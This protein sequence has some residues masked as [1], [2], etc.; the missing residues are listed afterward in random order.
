M[1]KKVSFFI[2]AI[3]LIILLEGCATV[4]QETVEL[5]YV[6]EENIVALKVSYIKLV[7]THF[8][9]LEQIRIDYL[10]KDWLPGYIK[11]WVD[12]GRLIDIATG[13]VVWSSEY[14]DYVQPKKDQEM[15]GLLATTTVWSIVAIKQ[16]E[17]KKKELISPLEDQ[18]KELLFMIEEGFDRLL[19]GNIAITAHLNSIR[20]IKESQNKTF[21][22]LK[23]GDLQREIDRRLHDISMY[24]DQGLEA[25]KKN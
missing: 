4:P 24:A 11:I 22:D 13:K 1:K 18:R 5:S 16:I 10:E 2:M 15:Q 12:E 25:I 7:N 3:L 14:G 20:K 8:D 23:F 19:R 17:E 21:E 9:L 6:M